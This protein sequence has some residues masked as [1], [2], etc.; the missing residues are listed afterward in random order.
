MRAAGIVIDNQLLAVT[1]R[2]LKA[3]PLLLRD[4]SGK[5]TTLQVR[6]IVVACSWPV[7]IL[8]PQLEADRN[9]FNFVNKTFHDAASIPSMAI[10]LF[11]PR[12]Q[13]DLKDLRKGVERFT[14]DLFKQL[15]GLGTVCV[16]PARSG[17]S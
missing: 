11:Q 4:R 17:G 3:P 13:Q 7:V 9:R 16:G 5:E 8:A 12:G 6:R 15:R 1:G 10:F 14:A 2:T